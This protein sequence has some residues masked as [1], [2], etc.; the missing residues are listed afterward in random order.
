MVGWRESRW[1]ASQGFIHFI[2]QKRLFLNRQI[3]NLWFS[4][5]KSRVFLTDYYSFLS[6]STCSFA[7]TFEYISCS[8]SRVST[9]D[10]YL[11]TSKNLFLIFFPYPQKTWT[12]ETPGATLIAIVQFLSIE[13]AAHAA[14]GHSAWEALS[15]SRYS[16]AP[17]RPGL[18]SPSVRFNPSR[19]AEKNYLFVNARFSALNVLSVRTHSD[20]P[21]RKINDRYNKREKLRTVTS[22]TF[23]RLVWRNFVWFFF[24]RKV[25]RLFYNCF[26]FL[27]IYFLGVFALGSVIL[28][29]VFLNRRRQ[30]DEHNLVSFHEFASGIPA[31]RPSFG[32]IARSLRHA[33]KAL[34]PPPPP[35]LPHVA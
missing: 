8:I 14:P 28:A 26:F 2:R 31:R 7:S 1:H 6:Y 25:E 18:A 17:F 12:P 5:E 15:D 4:Y 16:G 35:P 29:E 23:Q 20:S 19:A 9:L 21:E 3:W 33:R 24:W 34:P 27:Y 32:F 30:R 11:R 22:S 13:Y 10:P